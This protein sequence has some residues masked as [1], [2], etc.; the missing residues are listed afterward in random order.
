MSAKLE[1]TLA[2]WVGAFV[3]DLRRRNYSEQTLKTYRCDLML[4][5]RWVKEQPE[6]GQP[7]DLTLAALE[8]YQMHLMVRVSYTYRFCHPRTL[9]ASAR[10]RH[11][12]A[13][14]S[15]FRFL[16]RSGRLL[17]NPSL[18][19]EPARQ[20][21][22]LPKDVLS[23]P[24][25]TRLLGGCPQDTPVGLRNLAALEVLYGT[26]LRRMELLRLNVS[27]LRLG[28]GLA[29]ILGKGN[30]ER[31]VPL[32][33]AAVAALER[34]LREGRPQ[35]M[36]GNLPALWLSP[37]HG[38]RASKDELLQALKV[39]AKQAGIRKRIGF[40]LFRHTCATHLLRGGAD[41]R[42]I[43]T[44]LG[45]SDLNTTAIYTRVEISDLQKIIDQC[46]PREKDS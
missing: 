25:M 37:H 34:Y 7:G 20:M 12:A 16:K 22:R 33:K 2:E 40:H 39:M 46:H 27:D 23:V 45:H 6:L 13:L 3:D 26:G 29:Y 18:E 5:A 19:L 30:K 11:L 38:G 10:N 32:G 9:T 43:Q 31:L 35:L 44:L 36:K 42:S 28:E 21:R 1:G 17:G 14:R 24:E 8:S 4:F 15:F 41:L